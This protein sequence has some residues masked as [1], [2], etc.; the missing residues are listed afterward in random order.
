MMHRQALLSARYQLM[1]Q[2]RAAAMAGAVTQLF[3]GFIRIMILLAFYRSGTDKPPMEFAD[4]VTYIWLGQALLALLPWNHDLELEGFI[5]EGNVA[6]ELLRP[7]D[8]YAA[9]SMRT[10]ATRVASASLRAIP[11]IVLAG[12]VLPI[13]GFE[14]WRLAG[15]ASL[16]SAVA[17]V[18]AMGVAIVLGCALT[19]LVH[20]SLLWTISGD[21]VA[22]LMPAL[23]T[24][25]SGMVI[26]LPLF[27]D[28]AQPL[29]GALPFR[30]LVDVPYRLY[31][32]DIPAT[33]AAGEIALGAAWT[34]AIIWLGRAWLERGKRVLVVQG[35]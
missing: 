29:L 18:L 24:I 11:I 25:F 4:V 30:A 27:P 2:Y 34:L 1:L 28:W 7:I 3:W 33:S 15:P 31:T 8:L 6:Y 13:V 22:R 16:A 17:F 20:V 5:R 26:P 32:G 21:G 14:D 9:W 12:F 23:V 10:M 35:G 19:M